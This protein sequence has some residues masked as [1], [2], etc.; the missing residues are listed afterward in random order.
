MPELNS[1]FHLR[2]F[3]KQQVMDSLP[4]RIFRAIRDE[5]K[6]KNIYGLHWGDPDV[7]PP[8]KFIKEQYVL[9]FVDENQQALEIGPGGGRWTRYLLGFKKLYLV[10]Y[11]A[12]ILTEL[13]K[14]FDLPEM[15]FIKNN[16]AD[17]PSVPEK[18]IDFLFSFGTFVHLELHLIEAYLENMKAVLRPGAN[19]VIQYSDM[20]KIMAQKT[21]GFVDN[22][23]ARMRRMV[24]AVGYSLVAEDLTTLW[25]SS[26]IHFRA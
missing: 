18:S 3:R 16:G 15:V 4:A 10:D 5:I 12:E 20:T 7:A 19:V 23:P 9:P 2:M 6:H 8:L 17:F 25:H 13:K 26:L 24:G 22:D 11:H 21:A 14:N 1:S